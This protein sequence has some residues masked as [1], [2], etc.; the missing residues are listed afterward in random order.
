[1]KIIYV[2]LLSAFVSSCVNNE[3]MTLSFSPVFKLVVDSKAIGGSTIFYSDEL[4]LKMK[5]SKL[6]SAAVLSSDFE[7]LPDEFDIRNY[8]TYLLGIEDLEEDAS[9]TKEFIITMNSMKYL[10]DLESV[11]ILEREGVTFYTTCGP[12]NCLGYVVKGDFRGH[13]LSIRS[14]EIDQHKFTQFLMGAVDVK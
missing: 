13:I 4:S 10:Y 5:D 11:Q 9:A 8:P 3:P 7:K 14:S 2:V 12:E 6:I 1:M